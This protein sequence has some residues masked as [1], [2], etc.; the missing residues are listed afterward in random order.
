MLW[1]ERPDNWRLGAKP[2]QKAFVEVAKAIASFEPLTMGV[3]HAQF[4]NARN[5]LP[6]N[7]RGGTFEQRF[8]DS[9]LRPIFCFER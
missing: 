3:S 9:R 1:P 7:I 2:A 6:A 5:M 8:V 4:N